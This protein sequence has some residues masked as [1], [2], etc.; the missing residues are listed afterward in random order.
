VPDDDALVWINGVLV[1]A[2]DAVVS[3][4][5][6]G[7]VVGDAA[8]E[9]LQIVDRVPFAMTRHIRRLH[10]TLAA[11][12]VTPP[13]EQLLRSALSEVAAANELSTGRIRLTVTA[14]LGPLGS[15]EPHGPTMVVAA[16][17]PIVKQSSNAAVTVGWTRNERGALAGL[18]T[19]SYAENVRALRLAH[20]SGASE[21]LFANTR[22]ELCEGTGTN[23]FVVVDGEILTPPLSSGCLAGVTRELLLEIVDITETDLG[24][25]VLAT[26][27]E[28]FLTS[29]TRNVQGLDLVDGREV[30]A[31]GPQT[32]R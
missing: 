22:G 27:D 2:A 28:V 26:A 9:T 5:D 11:L 21:A 7:L 6:H 24:F 13:G 23:V 4:M 1:R 32:V 14:G 18:K 10:T 19:T 30:D 31:P 17:E 12:A 3:V 16:A 15:G 8:F 29:S 20:E 25:D